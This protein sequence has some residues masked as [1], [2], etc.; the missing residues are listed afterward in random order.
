MNTEQQRQQAEDGRERAE[1]ERQDTEKRR[2]VDENRRQ[3]AE[4]QR[5]AGEQLREVERTGDRLVAEYST[6]ALLTRIEDVEE[7]FSR[8]ASR[9]GG[10]EALL[11]E[12]H[13][14]LQ[15]LVHSDT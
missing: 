1:D 3:M 5:Q 8:L 2:N 14:Q 11:N 7:Q 12:M 10:V 9:L 13:E 4:K 15:R 6:R